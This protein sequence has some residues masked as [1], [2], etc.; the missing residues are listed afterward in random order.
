MA[1]PPR[2]RRAV[3]STDC[4]ALPP[5][6]LTGAGFADVDR[7]AAPLFTPDT[8]GAAPLAWGAHE[9]EEYSVLRG[10]NSESGTDGILSSD[11][12]R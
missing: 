3:S 12:A 1:G 2:L 5:P 4:G 7:T 6:Q 8:G 10:E 11:A 9:L